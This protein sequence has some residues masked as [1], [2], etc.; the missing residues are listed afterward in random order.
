MAKKSSESSRPAKLTSA[1]ARSI[2]KKP[3]SKRQSAV[4]S[5]I[6]K[7]Q[8]A[9]DDSAINYSDIPSLSD[10]LLAGAF[11]PRHKQLISVRLDRDVLEWLKGYGE[12][13]SSRLNAILRAVMEHPASSRRQS[14]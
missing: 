4:L 8:A 10:E 14:L 7:R 6:A 9:D 5:G 2:A 3:L 1:S 12:G 11:R 13:Y